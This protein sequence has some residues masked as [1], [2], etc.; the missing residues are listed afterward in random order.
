M[1]NR[2]G[3]GPQGEGRLTGRRNGNCKTDKTEDKSFGQGNGRGQGRGFKNRDN[4]GR[5]RGQN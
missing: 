2:D 4:S 5:G 1:P 3:T